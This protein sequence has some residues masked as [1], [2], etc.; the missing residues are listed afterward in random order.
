[1]RSLNSCI[2]AVCS[3]KPPPTLAAN[4]WAHRQIYQTVRAARISA[5]IGRRTQGAEIEPPRCI[6][7][8]FQAHSQRTMRMHME[9]S[10]S[11]RYALFLSGGLNPRALLAGASGARFVSLLARRSTTRRR[12]RRRSLTLFIAGF[13]FVPR[14]AMPYDGHLADAVCYG[15]GQ[16]IVTEAHFLGYLDHIKHSAVA[17]S[18]ASVSMFSSAG[19]LC[20]KACTL[21]SR[22]R[23]VALQIAETSNGYHRRVLFERQISPCDQRP[24]AGCCV[25][26]ARS[27]AERVISRS[28]RSLSA[29]ARSVPNG[30]IFG[31]ICICTILAGTIPS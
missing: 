15:G 26:G 27:P 11:R 18:S 31:N 21:S 29:A 6:R 13:E 20:Q 9:D 2:F 1:M 4:C 3:A 22:P 24:L 25:V 17:S 10:A 16:H 5:N 28:S 23:C 8:K 14:P 19:S 7:S 30:T 12:W